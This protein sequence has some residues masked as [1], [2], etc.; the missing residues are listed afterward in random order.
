MTPHPIH[1]TD[2][3]APAVRRALFDRAVD[4]FPKVFTRPEQ[5]ADLFSRVTVPAS[6]RWIYT[7]NAKTGGSSVR[8]FLFEMEFG[9]PLTAALASPMDFNPDLVSQS[10]AAAGV[11]RPLSMIPNGLAVLD[12][13]L[14]LTTARHPVGRALSSFNYLCRSHD[15]ASPRLA[16]DRLR[17]N[18]LVGF[19]WTADC[20]TA[21]GFAKFL[22][23]V[24]QTDAE[25]AT[26]TADPHLRPQVR[27]VLPRVT[28]PAI[29]GRTE[30]LPA[31]CHAVA[32]ALNQPL[33]ADWTEPRSNQQTYQ[34]APD[35][36]LT[37]SN[38]ALLRD[39]FAADFDWLKEEPDTWHPA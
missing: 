21:Q 30:D 10:L 13:G 20:D 24:R 35:T 12:A 37:K 36:L 8:R 6:H 22:D 33:P 7:G 16:D 25:H 34:T 4:R 26:W 32:D 2:E 38:R 29:I 28:R 27:N 23:Y 15:A 5:V 11:F 39:V 1:F 3:P 18:A 31:F 14:R 19:D 17:M 9:V